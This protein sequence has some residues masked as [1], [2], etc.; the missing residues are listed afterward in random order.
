MKKIEAKK[1]LPRQK[2]V[3]DS[4]ARKQGKKK[5][6]HSRTQTNEQIDKKTDF[7]TDLVYLDVKLHS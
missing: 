1:Q 3:T 5:V 4:T 7:M 6:R 2:Y